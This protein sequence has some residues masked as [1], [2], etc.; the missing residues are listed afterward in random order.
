MKFISTVDSDTEEVELTIISTNGEEQVTTTMG[1]EDY[2]QMVAETA[3][4]PRVI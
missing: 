1:K 3:A 4:K 2:L